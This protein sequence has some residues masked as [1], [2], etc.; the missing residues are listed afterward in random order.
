MFFRSFLSNISVM[1]IAICNELFQGWPI[2]KVFQYAA[3]LGYNG[4]QIAP[5][6]LANSV[7]D[8]SMDRRRAIRRA[9]ET[10]GVEI[11]G[12]HS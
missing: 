10:S 11:V 1:K 8:V 9:A 3:Q 4:V 5:F 12:L 2:K 6:T 7:L